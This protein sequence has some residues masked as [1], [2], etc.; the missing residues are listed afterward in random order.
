MENCKPLSTPVD[1]GSKLTKG[2]EDSEYIDK[3][4]SVSGW[5]FSISI[6]ENMP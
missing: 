4:L 1:V 3:T 6:H 5:K 2:T